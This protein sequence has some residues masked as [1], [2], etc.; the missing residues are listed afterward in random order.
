MGEGSRDGGADGKFLLV[1]LDH[2]DLASGLEH[3][4]HQGQVLPLIF[5]MMPCVAEE[6]PVDRSVHKK[7]VIRSCENGHNILELHL[8]EAAIHVQDHVRV[9]VDCEDLALVADMVRKPPCKVS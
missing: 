1:E 2:N 9:D 4:L 5:D 3:F 7:R 8:P 6:K